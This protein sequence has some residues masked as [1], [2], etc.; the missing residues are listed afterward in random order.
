MNSETARR[1][2][3]LSAEPTQRNTAVPLEAPRRKLC[4][5]LNELERT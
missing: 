4:L 1:E 2:T 5:R 3:D